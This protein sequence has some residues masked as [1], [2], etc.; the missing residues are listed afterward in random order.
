M[1]MR[2]SNM[3][4]FEK[5]MM[6]T[7]NI[8]DTQIKIL[9]KAFQEQI[10]KLYENMDFAV[11]ETRD[12]YAYRPVIKRIMESHTNKDDI[13]LSE[14][15]FEDISITY[16]VLTKTLKNPDTE[17]KS[18]TDKY[19]IRQMIRMINTEHRK[20][21]DK[22]AEGERIEREFNEMRDNDEDYHSK[23][24]DDP[25]Y[26]IDENDSKYDAMLKMM[27]RIDK[28]QED[29]SKQ[30]EKCHQAFKDLSM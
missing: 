16:R 22:K 9:E 13:L 12:K 15:V 19:H 4:Y 18:I 5:D 1:K 17:L 3:P 7:F 23:Y 2:T 24:D 29:I 14:R 20:W 26:A 25:R 21:L 8:S 6:I 30:I 28:Q 10:T 27:R 11:A